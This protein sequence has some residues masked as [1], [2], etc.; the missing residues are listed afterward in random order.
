M[1]AD[2][3]SS[4]PFL[5]PSRP[6]VPHQPPLHN[7]PLHMT[8]THSPHM[9]TKRSRSVRCTSGY[10]WPCV[11]R[12]ERCSVAWRRLTHKSPST[13][14]PYL[15]ATDLVQPADSLNS[16]CHATE[17]EQEGRRQVKRRAAMWQGGKAARRQELNDRTS[18]RANV[19]A[20][21]RVRRQTCDR[22][23]GD[24][25]WAMGNGRQCA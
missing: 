19:G 5:S 11:A 1:P 22:R 15:G 4:L 6:L 13:G 20:Q 3:V 8:R 21:W 24:G 9:H 25:R 12:F 18:E 17:K 10:G 7:S 2:G 23:W 14:R 16:S